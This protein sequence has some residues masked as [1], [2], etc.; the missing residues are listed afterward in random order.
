MNMIFRNN[1][2][3]SS[4]PAGFAWGGVVSMAMTLLL[5]AVLAWLIISEKMMQSQIGFAV[6]VILTVSSFLGAKAAAGKIRRRLLLVCIC[7]GV[8]YLSVLLSITALFFGGQYS[9]VGESAMLIFCGS[10][11]AF[12]VR[13]PKRNAGNIRKMKAHYR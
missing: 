13:K 10:A 11:L 7:S 9:G 1:G 3:A 6:M 5:S 2:R 8:V 4:M 12:L